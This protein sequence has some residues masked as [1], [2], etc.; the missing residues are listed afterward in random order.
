MARILTG[1]KLINSVR[2]RTMSPDDVSIFNDDDI[3]DIIDEEVQVQ[4]LDKLIAL[5]GENLTISVDVARNSSGAYVIPYRAVGN[6]LRDVSL[7]NGNQIYELSQV[8]IGELPDYTIGQS[9]SNNLD[10]CY[11]ENNQL[12]LVDPSVNYEYIRMRYY[13]RPSYLTKL[14][15]AGIISAIVSDSGAGTVTL[16]MSQMGKNF[17]ASSTFDIVQAKTPNKI[18][19]FDLTPATYVNNG[20]TGTITFA[21]SDLTNILTDLAVGDYVSLAEETPVPN[22]PTEM[23]PLVAQA[24]AVNILES[25][26]DSEAL[27]NAE[28]KLQKI[29]TAVQFLIDD[30]VELAP[31]KIKPRYNTLRG[32]NGR[33]GSY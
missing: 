7:I 28:R 33:R 20:T 13:L 11:V 15:K 26:T 10:M 27:N 21:Y 23:H 4:V 2:T 5:H 22:I 24:A 17:T 14:D 31:K 3:L 6:K 9:Y 12:K 16:S 32:T 30:R 29:V 19:A 1:D 25:L 18:R 8:S